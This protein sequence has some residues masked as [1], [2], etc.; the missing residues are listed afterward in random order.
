MREFGAF[1]RRQ[2]QSSV[3]PISFFILLALTLPLDLGRYEVLLAG[4]LVIQFLL[5]KKGW[6]TRDELLTITVFHLAGLCLEIYKVK[7]GSWSYPEPSIT[8]IAGV[9]LFSGF[10]Y[11]SVASYI[12]QAWR[13][14]DLKMIKWPPTWAAA[15]VVAAIYINFFTGRLLGDYRW[16]V[17]VAV[18]L[19][20]WRTQ[21]EFTTLEKKRRRMPML[22]A[23]I[24]IGFFVY[25][26]ENICSGLGAYVYPDQLVEWRPVNVG[27]FSSWSLLVI[28]SVLLV[29]ELKEF[30][31]RRSQAGTEPQT[32]GLKV[33]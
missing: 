29:Y 22:L 7:H 4:C 25:V 16:W 30:K 31:A 1:T 21:V 20:F 9:P 27:K 13:R 3:F 2:L 8:K 12:T 18:S 14:F 28:F 10:M 19:I 5:L 23:F 17:V 6:E 26:A 11:G 32:E 33:A 15:L 24:A